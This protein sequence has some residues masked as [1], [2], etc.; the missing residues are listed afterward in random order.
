MPANNIIS[1]HGQQP[2]E[3]TV[4]MRNVTSEAK[5]GR[6]VN[7]EFLSCF[8]MQD[9]IC[10][11]A[12]LFLFL[13]MK[14]DFYVSYTTF[15]ASSY[16]RGPIPSSYQN[17]APSPMSV[18]SLPQLLRKGM[19]LLLVYQGCCSLSF[20][21]HAQIVLIYKNKTELS[22][23]HDLLNLLPLCSQ[24]SKSSP[25]HLAFSPPPLSSA[26]SAF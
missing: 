1:T 22:L 9:E 17:L 15:V 24:I 6:C 12:F 5:L 10:T 8:H 14:I 26:S 3:K 20:F 18:F 19:L 4:L 21:K 23:P 2:K 16:N 13:Q 7:K 11:R 25:P